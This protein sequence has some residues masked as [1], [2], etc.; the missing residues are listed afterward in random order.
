MKSWRLLFLFVLLMIAGCALVEPK[1]DS[2]T[3]TTYTDLENYLRQA[4][5]IMQS[6]GAFVP[7]WGTLVAG[8]GGLLSVIAGSITSVSMVR[9][10]GS[11]LDTVIKGVNEGTKVF[12]EVKTTLLAEMKTVLKPEDYT[13][14]EKILSEATPIKEIIKKIADILGTESYLHRRV[15]SISSSS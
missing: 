9:K 6:A 4:G 12:D 2:E 11:A 13:K 14:L 3:G 15:K 10:R 8:A 1:V 5:L 7:G